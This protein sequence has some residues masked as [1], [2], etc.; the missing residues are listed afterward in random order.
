MLTSKIGETIINCVDSPYERYQLKQWSNKNILKCPVCNDTYEYCHGEVV[1]PYFRHK[2]KDCSGYYSEPETE[3]HKTGK[4]MLYNWI[5]NQEG[6][7]NCQLEAWIPETK[8][9]PDIYF[10]FEGQKF[11][12][13]YQCSPIA[14]EYL[15]RKELY[16]L[17]G[18]SDI[19][20][21]GTQKYNI[22]ADKYG[23]IEYLGRYRTIEKEN[24][25]N[26]LVYLDIHKKSLIIHINFLTKTHSLLE[27]LSNDT[28]KL[29]FFRKSSNVLRDMYR[30][31]NTFFLERL[32]DLIFKDGLRLHENTT[33]KFTKLEAHLN[34]EWDIEK[35]KVKKNKRV[36]CSLIKK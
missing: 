26:G 34:R 19:W 6:V 35:E 13:E 14:S 10:E 1:S 11:V 7:T 16:K 33:E 12:I 28:S 36:F 2:D 27:G 30:L 31:E 5:K 15:L 4:I 20:I 24:M 32:D 18:I 8:Q 23:R 9:R 17:A 25:P 29:N 21:L 3:E 22:K